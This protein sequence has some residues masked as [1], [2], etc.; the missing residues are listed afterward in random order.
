MSLSNIRNFSII[1][2]IDHGKSTLADRLLETTHTIS[3]RDYKPQ[4]LDSM[5]LERERGI[6]I[7]L[8]AVRMDY[9]DDEG[10]PYILNLIDTPGHVDFTYEVSRALAAC[11]G[12]LLV[13]D[14][15]QGIE[16]QTM[17]NFYLALENNL[18]IIPIINKIDLPSADVQRVLTEIEQVLGIPPS[19][20]ICA[21]AKTGQ[22]I[23]EILKAIVKR[24]P[25]PKEDTNA[26]LKALIFDATYDA[27]RGVITFI[28]VFS[29]AIQKGQKIQLM[30]N[31][32]SFEVLELGVFKPK[33]TPRDS[34][35][36]GEV[37]YLISNIK[38]VKDAR[39]G[40][41]VTDHI[42]PAQE[43]LPG[44]KE[45]K[46]MVF[47]GY[48]PVDTNDY[49]NLKDALEKLRL[50][51]A[52]LHFEP[53]TSQ[54]LGFGYRCGF[55]GLL[56][57]EII[58]ERIEREFGIDIVATA[59]NVTYR[60][61]KTNDEVIMI[62]NPSFYPE[63]TQIKWVEEPIMGLSIITP[64]T[65]LSVVIDLVRNKRGNYI[66]S[67]YLDADRQLITFN[68]PLNELINQFFDIL[69]SL[70]K[71][72]A[73]MDYWFERFQPTK[74]VKVNMLINA[75]PVDALSFITHDQNA[76]KMAAKIAE[77]LKNLI[78]RQLYEVV[79]QGAIGGKIICRENIKALRKNVTAKCY[80]GDITRKRKLLEKQKEGKKKMKHLGSID[81]PK[82]AFL[83]VLKYD[84]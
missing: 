67:D 81:V 82:E 3:E 63:P 16:A 57:M 38:E 13:V 6:T 65:Y 29:G 80:G 2:H 70:T 77:R 10:N 8:Q 24:V 50:N 69:K 30:A 66:K 60:V 79:I 42:R 22:G 33:M 72:Y 83:S 14:A 61:L 56:H 84:D 32:K 28:R 21:S 37:G 35:K 9:A 62:E 64:N 53:E 18:E 52:S 5:D 78:P 74:L 19:D 46:P 49:P 26:A 11:E 59:P 41:T 75:E 48:Y 1:A 51:D 54:A 68:I 23:P 73:S 71:G 55:L 76:R 39:V 7:K 31:G 4:I 47:C 40:D 15:S 27:Y 44:Y 34:L 12:A 45:I 17:A 43:P 20:C 36:M 25:P 58:Q